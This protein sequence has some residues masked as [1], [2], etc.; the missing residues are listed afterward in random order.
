MGGRERWWVVV[1]AGRVG[2]GGGRGGGGGGA[3]G[4]V[5][6]RSPD[7]R[8]LESIVQCPYLR[9]SPQRERLCK[10]RGEFDPLA[11]LG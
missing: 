10:R 3:V 5:Y 7:S 4:G 8:L 2:Q 1:V 9:M 6:L 11:K